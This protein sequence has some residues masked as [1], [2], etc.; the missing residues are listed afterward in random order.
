M[1]TQGME[2]LSPVESPKQAPNQD[3]QDQESGQ[4]LQN[5][6]EREEET[7][8]DL[9][10]SQLQGR[11][12]PHIPRD[13]QTRLKELET[14]LAH[15]KTHGWKPASAAPCASPGTRKKSGS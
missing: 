2:Q 15:F 9:I 11:S 7:S 5:G 14:A 4:P 3:S 1:E 8:L 12:L 13:S 6:E 10:S